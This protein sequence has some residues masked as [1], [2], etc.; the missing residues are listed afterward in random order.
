MYICIADRLVKN[1]FKDAIK[2]ICPD[3]QVEEELCKMFIYNYVG[4]SFISAK[5]YA[6]LLLKMERGCPPWTLNNYFNDNLSK[7]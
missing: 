3:S 4:I 6:K 7:N 2:I 1:F 5:E